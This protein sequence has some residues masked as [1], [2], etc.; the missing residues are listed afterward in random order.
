MKTCSKCRRDLPLDQ[1]VKSSRYRDGKYP[2]CKDCRKESRMKSLAA[3]P[4]CVRCKKEP[5]YQT[6]F[7]CLECARILQGGL[8]VRQRHH[9][10]DPFTCPKCGGP[11]KHRRRWCAK[12]HNEAQK[13]WL[14]SKGGQWAYASSRGQRHKLVARRYVM[15][16]IERGKLKRKPCEVCGRL[17]V[18]A[19]HNTY[20]D[21]LDIRWLCSEHHD[22]LER[23]LFKKRKLL[24][25]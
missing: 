24:T 6:N 16:M 23:W 15:T 9:S 11:R 13:K 8:P 5:H 25:V 19:H 22:A 14:K 20:E 1:F 18:E 17:E 7:Y 4:L 12:C 3:N 2:L 10:K 21:P